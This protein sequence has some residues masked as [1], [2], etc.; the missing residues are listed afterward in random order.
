MNKSVGTTVHYV[1]ERFKQRYADCGAQIQALQSEILD[2]EP[3][4]PYRPTLPDGMIVYPSDTRIEKVTCEKCK[5]LYY[6][7]NK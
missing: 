5:E 3:K 4:W 6:E 1:K 7:R 2:L